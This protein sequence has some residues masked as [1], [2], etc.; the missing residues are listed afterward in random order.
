VGAGALAVRLLRIGSS[1]GLYSALCR[2]GFVPVMIV[3]GTW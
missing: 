1:D 2:R 3:A